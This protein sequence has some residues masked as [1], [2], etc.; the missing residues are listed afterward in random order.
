MRALEALATPWRALFVGS[1]PLEGLLRAWG[2]RYGDQ[3]RVVTGVSHDD[4]PR[5]LNAMDMLCAPSQT[6]THWREQFGRMIIEA[7]A[8]GVPVIGSSSGEIPYVV[9]NA[10]IV[11][12]ESDLAL[13]TRSI[14]ELL[15]NPSARLVL[16]TAGRD[17]AQST[18]AWPHIARQHVDFFGELL[19]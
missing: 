9:G 15:E 7:F 12:A 18:Y 2:E 19:G 16:S 11:I 13:W 10:G 1:G 17:R 14:G 4:V 6:T 3:V 8:C 5:Y